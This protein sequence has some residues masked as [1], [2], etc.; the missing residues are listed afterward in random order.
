MIVSIHQPSY[1]P[2]LGWLHKVMHSDLFILMDD[3]QLSDSA[4]QHRNLFLTIGGKEKYLSVGIRKKEYKKYSIKDLAL[5]PDFDWQGEHLR[6]LEANYSKHPYYKEVMEAVSKVFEQKYE[7]LGQVLDDVTYTTLSLFDIKTKVVK[8]SELEY[9]KD[10][11]KGDLVIELVKV[12]DCDTYLSGKGAREYM[13]DSEY[14]KAGISL[15]YQEFKHPEYMQYNSGKDQFV[16]GISSLDILFNLG[17][18][19]ARKVLHGI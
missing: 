13:D 1:F 17:I 2:W 6:F 11:R 14:E 12:V 3:V 18:E 10:V 15:I 8:Q 16:P 19:Q 4:Y 5:R 7:T 9:D